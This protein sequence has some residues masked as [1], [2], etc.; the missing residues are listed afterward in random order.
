MEAN[1]KQ[2]IGVV[3]TSSAAWLED[4]SDELKQL[5]MKLDRNGDGVLDGSELKQI[6][7]LYGGL[8]EDRTEDFGGRRARGYFN[9]ASR[10]NHAGG[11]M[12]VPPA[13][14]IPES[15]PDSPLDSEVDA[16]SGQSLAPSA[17]CPDY[18]L[19]QKYANEDGI[20][21]RID[22][23]RRRRPASPSSSAGY[24]SRRY[25]ARQRAV[26]D[27]RHAQQRRLALHAS[28]RHLE[29]QARVKELEAELAELTPRFYGDINPPVGKRIGME[30]D[31]RGV[32]MPRRD[33]KRSFLQASDQHGLVRPLSCQPAVHRPACVHILRS[34][35]AAHPPVYLCVSLRVS[36]CSCA[37]CAATP[38]EMP[39][40]SLAVSLAATLADPHSI[41]DP[42]TLPGAQCW[43]NG[44][45]NRAHGWQPP[46]AVGRRAIAADRFNR[47]AGTRNKQFEERLAKQQV[48]YLRK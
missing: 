17:A 12:P 34:G 40:R 5:L 39:S 32:G 21:G 14:R 36:A 6:E 13:P 16:L 47:P 46:I 4:C 38:V 8:S 30:T 26:Q 3:D 45:H 15:K 42:T 9:A 37:L 27:E 44:F 2:R 20:A 1:L 7:T 41:L 28:P 11:K 19:P 43:G 29:A 33:D 31:A 25:S 22:R 10:A 35:R 23:D 48:F 18:S 24:T